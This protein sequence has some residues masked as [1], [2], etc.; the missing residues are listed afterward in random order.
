[1]KINKEQMKALAAKSDEE[2]WREVMNLAAGHGYD[3]SG[4]KPKK[5]DLD[6]V[7]RALTGVEKLSLMEAAKLLNN[8]KKK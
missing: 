5:E 6:K 4:S 3:L 7:R 8:Y 1:M 2:L